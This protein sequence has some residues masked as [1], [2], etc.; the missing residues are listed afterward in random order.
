MTVT[1]A[2][3]DVLRATRPTM[4]A[5]LHL[6]PNEPTINYVHSSVEA[7][8]IGQLNH[9]DKV[10]TLAHINLQKS[11]EKARSDGFHRAQFNSLNQD[12]TH[13]H[14]LNP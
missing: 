13:T 8:R 12:S 10:L 9:G 7:Q 1:K 4:N 2:E 3:Q 6:R 14:V 11:I 5:E